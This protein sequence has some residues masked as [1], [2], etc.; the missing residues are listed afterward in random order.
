[1]IPP[2]R[3]ERKKL[4]QDLPVDHPSTDELINEIQECGI[5]IEVME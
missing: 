4:R 3:R 5:Q 2:I 1:M